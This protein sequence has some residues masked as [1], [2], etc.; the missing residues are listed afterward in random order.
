MQL[1]VHKVFSIRFLKCNQQFSYLLVFFLLLFVCLFVFE[2]ESRS[3][4]QA[5]VQWR[6]LSSLQPLPPRLKQFSHLKLPSSWD[7][8]R[9]PPR[10]AN[11]C[12]F[13]RDGVS[14]RWPDCS[15]TPDLK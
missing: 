3:V 2:V 4:A 5:G 9:V 13:S 1:L 7:Y 11:F 12:I 15:R 10:P 6:H 14:P 8:R